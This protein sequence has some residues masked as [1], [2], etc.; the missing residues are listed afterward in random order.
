M[1]LPSEEIDHH[2]WACV[3]RKCMSCPSYKLHDIES[4]D[5][6]D[7]P[8][9][10]FH[11]YVKGTKCTLQN[12]LA[13]KSRV[14]ELCDTFAEGQ[15][16]GKI[17][18][19]NYLTLLNRPI[20]SFVTKYYL[21]A[22]EEYA[23]HLPHVRILGSKVCGK[24]QN[25]W[26]RKLV[27][28]IRTIRDFAEALQMEFYKEIQLEH[29]GECLSLHIEG[30]SAQFI[31]PASC[32]ALDRREISTEKLDVVMKIHSHF[33]DCS[34]QDSRAVFQNTKTLIKVLFNEENLQKKTV[35]CWIPPMDV[36]S[37]TGLQQQCT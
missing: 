8:S 33:S 12:I 10:C 1:C 17:C 15:K 22:L 18:S 24:M 2:H 28:I 5:D 29:F 34:R 21:P 25:E 13:V 9:I 11:K 14:C 4:Q 3:M 31:S 35:L 27:Y 23:Y 6:H 32:A 36:P 26:F 37:S 19:R 7:S 16:K 20:R 30:S